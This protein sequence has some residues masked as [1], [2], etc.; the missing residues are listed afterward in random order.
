MPTAAFARK[1]RNRESL[2]G[3]GPATGTAC[4]NRRKT[5]LF[6]NESACPALNQRC[7]GLNH[8]ACPGTNQPGP[9]SRSP[10]PPYTPAAFRPMSDAIAAMSRLARLFLVSLVVL[11]A[12]PV[13]SEVPRKIDWNDLL[14]AIE[15]PVDP[16]LAL[17][18]D[19]DSM[20]RT[21]EHI[22]YQIREGRVAPDSTRAKQADEYA[23]Q[24]RDKG[25]DVD[26][27]LAKFNAY[28]DAVDAMNAAVNTDLDGQV[29]RMPG[30][31][32]PLEFDELVI[33]E[34]LLVPFVGACI[35]V[36]PPPA[37]QIVHVQLKGGISPMGLFEPVW[38]TGK[39]SVARATKTMRLA[40]GEAGVEVGY[41]IEQA[42]TTPYNR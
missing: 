34:F 25:V 31:L 30:F 38:V 22:R 15:E 1:S 10:R 14:P 32:L 41:V 9:L 4:R 28:L 40:D 12:T 5:G 11:A 29:I 42:R 3:L 33:K 6:R 24:L 16:L 18:E 8:R 20:L 21:I 17:P 27:M 36:P 2:Q 19:Q 26:D 35:H 37:N 23:A 7:P 13:H 39:L